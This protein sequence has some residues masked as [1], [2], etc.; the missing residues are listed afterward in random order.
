MDREFTVYADEGW[1]RNVFEDEIT[2]KQQTNANYKNMY[3]T[4]KY[5]KS[6]NNSEI[7]FKSTPGGLNSVGGWVRGRAGGGSRWG[8]DGGAE[9]GAAGK[10]RVCR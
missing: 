1:Q 7:M 6:Y 10:G 4:I 8:H 9:Q 3:R 2:Y 5:Y